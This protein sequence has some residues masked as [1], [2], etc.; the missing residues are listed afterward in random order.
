VRIQLW[1]RELSRLLVLLPLKD[2][3]PTLLFADDGKVTRKK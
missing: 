3:Q 1:L 2:E